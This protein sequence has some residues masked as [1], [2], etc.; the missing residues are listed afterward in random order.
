MKWIV[1]INEVT[2]KQKNPLVIAQT[3]VNNNLPLL[4]YQNLQLTNFPI[5]NQK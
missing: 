2:K 1:M 3:N 4:K 5:L